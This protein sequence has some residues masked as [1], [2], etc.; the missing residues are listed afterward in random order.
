MCT[1][2]TANSYLNI[3][4]VWL[5]QILSILPLRS[6]FSGI[7]ITF[8]NTYFGSIYD[9][10]F[11]TFISLTHE[12]KINK[13][14][15]SVE[16]LYLRNVTSFYITNLFWIIQGWQ[17][18]QQ[19]KINSTNKEV[20]LRERK[21]H[22]TRPVA[23]PWPGVRRGVP[24]GIPSPILTWLGRRYLGQGVGTLGYLLPHS[25]LAGGGG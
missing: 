2:L 11:C 8:E 5:G 14:I 16:M 9:K 18:C 19:S 7:I 22:T 24:W 25:D 6:C 23:S 21:R 13:E 12:M 4:L 3:S 1:C 17:R 20:L 10:L 15:Y